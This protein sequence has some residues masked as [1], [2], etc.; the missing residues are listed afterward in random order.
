MKLAAALLAVLVCTPALAEEQEW[1]LRIKK[2]AQQLSI[3]MGGNTIYGSSANRIKGSGVQVDKARS[4][5][6]FSRIRLDGPVD[7]RLAPAEKE[8]LR[9]QADDNIEPLVTTTVEG[10]TLVVGLKDGSS[11][12]TRHP[13]RVLVDF[14][15]LQALQIKG[16]G[17]AHIERLKGERFEL[18]LSG[19][20]D[21]RIGLL[22]VRE[23]TATLSGSGDLTVAGSA[24]QQDWSL[25]GS[26]DVSAA[27]L[28]GQRVKAR[29]SGSGDLRLGVSQELDASLSGSGDLSY[30]GRPQLRS[31][32][33]G[34][35]E[36]RQR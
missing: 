2:E 8:G 3:S 9:V 13:L 29:L 26:G 15:S 27:S 35:G 17:D 16:S 32:V 4:V 19:S 33:S 10:D 22:E 23:L 28:T 5:A 25:S 21:A 34:S 18:S 6:A 24:E 12:S 7:V 20:G 11:F 30:A 14:R 1:V 36:L 31:K